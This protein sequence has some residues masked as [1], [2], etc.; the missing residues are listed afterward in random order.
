MGRRLGADASAY[1]ASQGWTIHR[2]VYG[3]SLAV[4]WLRLHVAMQ[5]TLV[6]DDPTSRGAA[7]PVRHRTAEACALQL[8]L[9]KRSHCSEKPAHRKK[10]NPRQ[11]DSAAAKAHH[12]Q[13]K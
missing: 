9:H 13:K 6:Q 7:K 2:L 5:G 12:S 8:L 11:H 4:Q 1:Q 10:I 3:A